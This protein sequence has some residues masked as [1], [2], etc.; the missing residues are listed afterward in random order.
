MSKI[1]ST[2]PYLVRQ[3]DSTNDRENGSEEVLKI[4]TTTVKFSLEDHQAAFDAAV[5]Y[6][7]CSQPG[8]PR[9][10]GPPRC[11]EDHLQQPV[12][13]FLRCSEIVTAAQQTR[14]GCPKRLGES[15]EP[16]AHA[17]YWW[18]WDSRSLPRPTEHSA[19]IA[20]KPVRRSKSFAAL[21]P[22]TEETGERGV[23]SSC[24]R[25]VFPRWA[26]MLGHWFVGLLPD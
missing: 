17:Q 12:E 5:V 6:L 11:G 10:S 3:V 9:E 26:Q 13:K 8:C 14:N 20:R 18:F 16:D 15:R 19:P 4:Y 25:V 22:N 23:R 7:P 1:K 24:P 21:R 2:S